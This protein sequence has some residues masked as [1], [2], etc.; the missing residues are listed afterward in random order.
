MDIALSSA[1]RSTRSTQPKLG[2][3]DRLVFES[4]PSVDGRSDIY[5]EEHQKRWEPSASVERTDVGRSEYGR[6]RPTNRKGVRDV[7][8]N[9]RVP[10][11]TNYLPSVCPYITYPSS[12]LLSSLPLINR[13]RPSRKSSVWD[14]P[15]C[16]WLAGWQNKVSFYLK[17]L[18]CKCKRVRGR[19][20][21]AYHSRSLSLSLSLSFSR[22]NDVSKSRFG[23]SEKQFLTSGKRQRIPK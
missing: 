15:K 22:V 3:A 14:E 8:T 1:R 18:E 9:S 7:I 12:P 5:E 6:G 21:A 4:V 13:T 20:R 17:V 16:I 10:P 19:G 11:P 23:R 2:S